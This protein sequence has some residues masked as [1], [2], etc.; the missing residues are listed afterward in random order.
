MGLDH[1]FQMVAFGDGYLDTP[2]GIYVRLDGQGVRAISRSFWLLDI[3]G[4]VMNL[5]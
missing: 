3:Y 2:L 4:H 1:L 5:F